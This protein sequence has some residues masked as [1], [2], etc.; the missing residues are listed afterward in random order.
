MESQLD[1]IS[2]HLS[3]SQRIWS[4][5]APALVL[6]AYLAVGLLVYLVRSAIR[7]PYR[8]AELSHRGSSVLLAMPVRHFFAWLVGPLWRLLRG[9]KL[10]ATALT[11]LSVFLA[12]AAAVAASAGR[13]ALAGWLYVSS[14]LCDFLDGRIARASGTASRAGAALDSILDRYSDTVILA[15]LAWYYRDNWV[16]LAVLA[17]ML[18]TFLVPYVRAKG[19]AMGLEIKCGLMQRPERIVYLGLAL[20]LSPIPEAVYAPHDVHPMHYLAVLAIVLVALS[21]LFTAGQRMVHLLRGLG[22]GPSLREIVSSGRN[23]LLRFS[24]ASATAT[25]VDFFLVVL[26]VRHVSL[27]PW[28]AT[29]IGCGLGAVVNFTINRTWAFSAGD[30]PAVLQ[31]G[32][33]AV[34]SGS[35]AVLNAGGVAVLLLLPR[36]DYRMAWWLA[37]GLVFLLWN[38]PLNR[39]YVFGSPAAEGS[40]EPLPRQ[41]WG[42]GVL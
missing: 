6:L 32:R 26:L 14:G 42:D 36:I 2:G 20:A 3:T 35:S 13:F 29:F 11:T 18:G 34:V 39:E 10:P 37:R 40:S 16:L 4:A 15:G 28:L 31:G 22:S 5:A 12:T 23:G 33:Y 27:P 9:A 1:F 7:G 17:L 8:D 30:S 25:A 38:Y 24:I 41:R 21:T 19:E